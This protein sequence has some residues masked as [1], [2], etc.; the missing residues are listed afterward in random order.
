[1]KLTFLGTGTSSGNPSLGCD[2]R[3]CSSDDSHDHRLRTSALLETERGTRLLID[4]GPD[5]R[6]Q[7]LRWISSLPVDS[8]LILNDF[9]GRTVI[10]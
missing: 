5:F 7:M 10:V 3:V 2:C 4:C 9:N 1:M 6:Y 8:S